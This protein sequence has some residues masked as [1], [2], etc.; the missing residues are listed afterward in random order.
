VLVNRQV[1]QWKE[2]LSETFHP[3]MLIGLF[4]PDAGEFAVDHFPL[5]VESGGGRLANWNG[6]NGG[7]KRAL[8]ELHLIDLLWAYVLNHAGNFA[9]VW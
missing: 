1:G 8:D 7:W 9:C 5:S 2:A 3:V 4:E 6:W